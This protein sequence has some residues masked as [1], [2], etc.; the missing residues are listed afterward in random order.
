[1]PISQGDN[2]DSKGD[3]VAQIVGATTAGTPTTPIGSDANG[4]L[5]T[6]DT[7]ESAITS[8]SITVSTTAVAARVGAAN[9]ATRKMLMISPVTNTVYIGATSAVTTATGI[10]IYPGQV[11]SFAFSA[12]VTPYLIS[13]ASGTVNIFEGA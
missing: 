12:N 5:F 11:I 3:I 1:V 10:P 9:L 4:N 2:Q 6:N 8:G 13:A 7:I